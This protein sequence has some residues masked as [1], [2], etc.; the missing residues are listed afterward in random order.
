MELRG[1]IPTGYASIKGDDDHPDLRGTVQFIP[2][3]DGTLVIVNVIGLPE[4]DTGFFALHIHEGGDCGGAGFSDTGSHY[5]P[6]DAEHPR[7]AGD[8]PPLLSCGGKAY[9]AVLTDRFRIREV[10]GKTVVIHAHPDDFKTQPSGDA[11][12]K[13]GCGV[14]SRIW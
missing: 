7:H 3:S 5:N 4:S 2:G 12:T 9:L 14:I 13:I 11:G 10:V 8:L 1:G 6:G